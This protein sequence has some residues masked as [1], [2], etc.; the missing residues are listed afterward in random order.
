MLHLSLI[1]TTV[2]YCVVDWCAFTH[3]TYAHQLSTCGEHEITRVVRLA[4][5]HK[6]ATSGDTVIHLFKGV[7]SSAL[8]RSK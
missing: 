5:T 6:I 8:Y 4:T 7:D 3:A 1:A 2:E